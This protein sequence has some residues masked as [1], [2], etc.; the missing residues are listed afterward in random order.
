MPATETECWMA[1]K[2]RID[3]LVTNPAMTV[4]EPGAVITPPKDGA[5]N[6]L[7]FILTSD[8][9][10]DHVRVS[11]GRQPSGRVL[12]RRSGTLI[13]SVQWP[14]SSPVSHAQL[15]QIGGGIAEH[16]PADTRMRYGSTCLRVTHDA[17]AQQPYHDGAYRVVVV[18]VRWSTV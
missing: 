7:P 13:L 9:R 14:L 4:A 15:V 1:L 12:H 2:S 6:P 16:F 5:N 3:T 8:I 11:I 17:D 18:R 10:N